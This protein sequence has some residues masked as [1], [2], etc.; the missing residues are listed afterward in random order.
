MEAN[1]YNTYEQQ[2]LENQNTNKTFN[3]ILNES[4][5]QP[6][7]IFCVEE[8]IKNQLKD[9]PKDR[10]FMLNVEKELLNF[11]NDEMY[12]FNTYKICFLNIIK[13]YLKKIKKGQIVINFKQ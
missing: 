3:T 2:K 5:Y 11:L 12:F 6:D 7:N 13:I 10:L 9:H 8:F 4:Q 1:S